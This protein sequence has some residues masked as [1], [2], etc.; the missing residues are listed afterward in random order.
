VTAGGSTFFDL[1][2]EALTQPR[3]EH[4]GGVRVVIRPGCTL[5]HDHGFYA[6]RSPFA[7]VDDPA[8]RFHPA[9]EL[10]AAV[11]S[12]PEPG[13]AIVG[14]GRRDTSFDQGLP[15]PISI[16]GGDG[17]RR[18][19]RGIT[20]DRVVDQHAFCRVDEGADLAVGEVIRFGVSHPCTAFDKWRVM[21]VLDDDD[22][23]VEAVATYF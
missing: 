13:L 10:W 1:A 11:S 6:Q 5:T 23:V 12:L 14:F 19:A 8:G 21:P 16:Q 3:P 20:V 22:V 2:A 15:V 9:L 7:A 17:T 18:D 4:A